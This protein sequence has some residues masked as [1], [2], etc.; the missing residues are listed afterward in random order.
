MRRRVDAGTLAQEFLK[1][2]TRQMGLAGPAFADENHPYAGLAKRVELGDVG[3]GDLEHLL[4]LHVPI[5]PEGCKRSGS[6]LGRDGRSVERLLIRAALLKLFTLLAFALFVFLLLPQLNRSALRTSARVLELSLQVGQVRD[7]SPV[8][9]AFPLLF[10]L[11]KAQQADQAFCFFHV[12]SPQSTMIVT[13]SSASFSV[14]PS[15]RQQA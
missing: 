13:P 12:V 9:G 1:H 10:T 15:P 4:L 8:L 7:I 14:L 11:G 5:G 6:V 2:R 3:L